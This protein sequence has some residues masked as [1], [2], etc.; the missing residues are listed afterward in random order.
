MNSDILGGPKFCLL[1]DGNSRGEFVF[2]GSGMQYRIVEYGFLAGE[3][4]VF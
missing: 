4:S 1:Q 3:N 2:L